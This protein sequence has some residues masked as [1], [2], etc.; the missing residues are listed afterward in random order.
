MVNIVLLGID[1]RG[2]TG[3]WRTDSIILLS[4]NSAQKTVSLL[5]IP[6]DLWVFIP[7]YGYER[8]NTADF[9]GEYT[10]YDHDDAALIK[11]TIEYN[12]GVP[13]H[14]YV[15]IDFEGFVRLV[16]L[17][18]GVTVCVDCP[19]G[20]VFP[21]PD[22]PGGFFWLSLAPGVHH[23]DG[24]TALFFSRSRLN[25]SDFDRARRQ[26]KVLTA[27]WER[28]LSLNILPQIPNLWD[29]LLESVKTDLTLEQVLSLAYLGMQ[30]KP[31][32]IKSLFIDRTMTLSWVTPQ[33]ASV[34]LPIDEKV[35]QVVE[36]LFSPPD[37]T[38]SWLAREGA[39]IAVLNGTRQTGLAELASARL[40]WEGFR[41]V[42]S[43]PADRQDYFA[44][45]IFDYSG[46]GYTLSRL[47]EVLGIPPASIQQA[48]DPKSQVDIT[49]ILGGDFQPCRR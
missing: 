11:Q 40:R 29:I 45:T 43:G 37:E 44:S 9:R 8:I 14:Y 32:R 46:K 17:L 28:T 18:G 20:D 30:L 35:R 6:R 47:C 33:G 5:S 15:R 34:L 12:L 3:G 41:V 7:G 21:D 24:K 27:L 42:S 4:V 36:K 48:F 10:G 49:V 31:E 1:R 39:K 19:I 26:Q 16:D 13:V 38:L 25:T 22:S 23:L 2:E